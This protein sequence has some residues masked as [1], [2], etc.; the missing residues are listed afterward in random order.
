MLFGICFS[1]LNSLAYANIEVL[2]VGLRKWA[3]LL[4]ELII[5]ICAGVKFRQISILVKIELKC[6]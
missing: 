5:G 3:Y 6:F 4:A 1:I 2:D